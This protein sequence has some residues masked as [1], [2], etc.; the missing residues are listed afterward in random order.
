MNNPLLNVY[1]TPFD[2]VPFDK[3]QLSD[4][5]PAIEQAMDEAKA[6]ID[7]ITASKE[8]P[9]FANTIA[10][11]EQSGRKLGRIA[12]IFFNL[13]SA[14]TSDAMQDLAQKLSPMLAAFSN[15]IQLNEALFERVKQ[16][17]EQANNDNLST[18]EWRLLDKTYKGFARNGALL[19]DSDKEILREIDRQLAELK[20]QFSKNVLQETNAYF[21]HVEDE[22]DL[23]GLP[24]SIKAMAAAEA[25][26]R[27]LPGWVFTL[28]FPSMTPLLKYAKN[29]DLR[30]QISL[31]AGKRAYKDNDFNNAGVVRKLVDLRHRRAQ[32]LGYANHASF[33]LEERMA[34]NP[35]AV[36][37]FLSELL[38]KAK[39]FAI[40]EVQGLQEMARK[41]GIEAMMPYDHAYYA[42]QQREQRF[43]FSEEELKPYFSLE[44]VLNAAF[45]AANKLYGLTFSLRNDIA[46]YHPEVQVYE[47]LEA[48]EHK[49]LLYADFH[50]RK[51][52]R[53]GAWMTS[54]QGQCRIEGKNLRPHVSIV[55]NFSRP[56]GE[57]PSLLT[58]TEVTTLFH[59]FGHALHGILADTTYESLAS[60]NVYWDFVEL[61]SQFMEN[62]CYEKE[63]LRSFAKHYQTGEPLDGDKIDKI[64][65]A[66]NFMEGYQTLRQL[67]FGLLDMAYHTN[68][69]TKEVDME[70]FEL[71]TL[72]DTR[73]YPHLPDTALSASFSHIFPGG[74]SSGYYSY[75]WAE[76]L[77]AD[78]FELFK[79]K[80][81]FNKDVADKFK[82]LLSK[83]G[84]ED[85]M[86]LYVD[87]RGRKPHVEALLK[88]AGLIADSLTE[89]AE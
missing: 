44:N 23:E 48:G 29:R 69:W 77:D 22:R 51:G 15:D 40:K 88:R 6:E 74:Y 26:E 87:F 14:E 59:E 19:N 62:F 82:T 3:I 64:I 34:A 65:A 45:D 12:E 54:F 1:G 63:F 57:A 37:D 49:A 58:F 66:A 70:Q 30:R 76:V 16:V 78:A 81:I 85:P 27:E 73:L 83:G 5:L 17:Y 20:V 55:C 79:E 43:S 10:R 56:T 18:E 38:L 84:T 67:S 50:P 71:A 24:P 41:E 35:N 46:V 75:K 32:L 2:S 80:G 13:D 36:L 68:Q 7:S 89:N 60:P 61:P 86:T 33:V 31:A 8:A 9:G 72:Q 21:L 52:K 42:E 39:P 4:Y 11:L 47:V 25:A 28:Q 53:P